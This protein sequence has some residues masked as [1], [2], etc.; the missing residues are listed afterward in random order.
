MFGH[1]TLLTGRKTSRL[2]MKSSVGTGPGVVWQ[3]SPVHLLV[4]A[5]V[6]SLLAG[7]TNELAGKSPVPIEHVRLEVI[8]E[9]SDIYCTPAQVVSG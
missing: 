1:S 8:E 6:S 5:I 4:V 2:C 3:I 7:E 9:M